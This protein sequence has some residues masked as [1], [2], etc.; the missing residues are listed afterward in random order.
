MSK[1]FFFLAPLLIACGSNT[2]PSPTPAPTPDDG[3]KACTPVAASSETVHVKDDYGTLEGTLDVPD[4]CA[5]MPVVVILSGSGP[6]DRNGDTPGEADKT[7]MYELLGR[8]LVEKGYATLRF[9]DPG[10]A[11]S[12]TALPLDE[13]KIVYEM[14]V[15]AAAKWTP[16]L[17]ADA[18]FGKIVA[19]GHS[20]GSL[21]AI[22]LAQRGDADA[23]ISL[24]GAGRPVDVVLREQLA[25]KLT[26]DQLAKLDAALAKM[27]A[28]ELAGPQDPPL[29][30]LLRPSVQ[31][32]MISWMK[33]DPK[34]EIA[35]VN[36]P[37]LLVQ[38]ETDVQVSVADANLLAEG[39][40]DAK[41]ELID[42]MCHVLKEAPKKDATTQ[43][44][45]YSDPSLP[46]HPAL[47]P[48]LDDFLQGFSAK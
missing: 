18:R 11:K 14:E 9:D 34:V 7:D 35:K 37:T 3:A 5:G 46:I 27:K 8:G 20:Q 29:D 48:D 33:Y 42:D 17:R 6:Q 31:P 23:V 40:P 15:D 4:G 32:Y 19:A 26:A 10:V 36:V 45:Q 16:L 2:D 22:L 12:K 44:A 41:L 25:P 24:A 43:A 30:V 13:S 21:T 28:G 47:V 1:N 38:G 39:K